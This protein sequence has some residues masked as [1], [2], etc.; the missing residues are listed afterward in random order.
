MIVVC[1]HLCY[2]EIFIFLCALCNH[3]ALQR[4]WQSQPDEVAT[5]NVTILLGDANSQGDQMLV[6]GCD[7]S[8]VPITVCWLKCVVHVALELP[9]F[10]RLSYK[11]CCQLAG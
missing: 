8:A 1:T 10:Q 9:L 2:C 4:R 7:H 3:G 11:T 5:N 6:D